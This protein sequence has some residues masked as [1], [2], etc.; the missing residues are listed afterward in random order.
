MVWEEKKSWRAGLGR[1]GAKGSFDSASGF[2][3][4]PV[5]S[6]VTQILRPPS[7]NVH[8]IH[9]STSVLLTAGMPPESSEPGPVAM[10]GLPVSR[11][12]AGPGIQ[13]SLAQLMLCS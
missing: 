3:L 6:G 2:L 7:L 4:L 9:S 5:E 8:I 10:G 1:V 12:V 13:M 11:A